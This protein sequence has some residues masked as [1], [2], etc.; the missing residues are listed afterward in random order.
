MKILN[1]GW[2]YCENCDEDGMVV[3]TEKV[4]ASYCIKVINSFVLAAAGVVR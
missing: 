2:L 1:I 3:K 4:A